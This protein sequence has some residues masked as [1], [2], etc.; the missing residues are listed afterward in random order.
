MYTCNLYPIHTCL[1]PASSRHYKKV[2]VNHIYLHEMYNSCNLS[3]FS[4]SLIAGEKLSQYDVSGRFDESSFLDAVIRQQK[5]WNMESVFCTSMLTIKKV[6][7][8][9]LCTVLSS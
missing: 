6:V 2:A 1:D 9:V 8:N 7:K 3:V 5:C 4:G